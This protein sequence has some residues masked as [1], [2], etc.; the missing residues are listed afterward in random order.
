MPIDFLLTIL[1]N[2]QSD[3]QKS[4][5]KTKVSTETVEAKKLKKHKANS[6]PSGSLAKV[7]LAPNLY[8]PHFVFLN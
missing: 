5:K 6:C 3:G 7:F 1:M 2:V 8:F 4:P